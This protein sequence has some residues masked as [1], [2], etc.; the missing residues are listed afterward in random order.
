MQASG[1]QRPDLDVLPPHSVPKDPLVSVIL[2]RS[3]NIMCDPE[4]NSW[5]N[6]YIKEIRNKS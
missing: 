4:I 2:M 3:N 5:G 6:L 1:G